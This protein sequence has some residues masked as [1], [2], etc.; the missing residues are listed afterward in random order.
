M[1]LRHQRFPGHIISLVHRGADSERWAR[2]V[3]MRKGG[4]DMMGRV[5]S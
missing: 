1:S 2:G 5:R 4:G 3:V